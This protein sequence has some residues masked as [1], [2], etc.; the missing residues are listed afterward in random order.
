MIEK[1]TNISNISSIEQSRQHNIRGF[2]NL[3]FDNDP[4][5]EGQF[6]SVH[7]VVNIDGEIK[8]GYLV[9]IC[10]DIEPRQHA[11]ETI[12]LLHE[13]ITSKIG[14]SQNSIYDKLPS[15]MGLPFIICD[16]SLTTMD[17]DC[18]AMLMFD[19][20]YKGYVDYSDDS[21]G[22]SYLSSLKINEKIYLAYE[23]TKGLDFLHS[24]NFIHCDLDP[25]SIYIDKNSCSIALIDFDSGYI[26]DEQ[27]KPTTIGKISHYVGGLFRNTIS[28]IEKTSLLTSTDRLAEEE[29][30]LTNLIFELI[31]GVVPYFFLV[32]AD[33]STKRAY[34]KEHTWP[35]INT[36]SKLFNDKNKKAHQDIVDFLDLLTRSG[37]DDLVSS[38]KMIFNRGY[39]DYKRRLN[40]ND[41]KNLLWELNKDFENRPIITSFSSNKIQVHRRDEQIDFRWATSM[42]SQIYINDQL[43]T[44]KQEK[45]LDFLNSTLVKLKVVNDF[46][47]AE[48]TIEVEAVKVEPKIIQFNSSK[49]IRNNEDPIQLNWECMDT[50]K[51]TLSNHE[52]EISNVDSLYVEPTEKTKY[53]LTAEGYFGEL[54]TQSIEVDIIRPDITTFYS[55][56]NLEHGIDNVDLIWKTK[57]THSV[58]IYPKIGLLNDD[59][60]ICHIPIN[61]ETE[62]VLE[63]QGLFTKTTKTITAKPFPLPVVKEILAPAPVFDFTT[64]AYLSTID[65]KDSIEIP[66]IIREVNIPSVQFTQIKSIEVMDLKRPN[67]IDE[68]L[69][70]KPKKSVSLIDIFEKIKIIVDEKLSVIIDKNHEQSN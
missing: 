32:D 4:I 37:V 46:G 36:E 53:V 57:N 67:Y 58:S 11:L 1:I 25:H 48:K 49:D 40:A 33:D 19:L 31:V 13:R 55:E 35:Q 38:F 16:A 18:T 22:S 26:Y 8:Q 70:V 17:E 9:K 28:N 2:E 63:A 27:L 39:S 65:F 47:S 62:F 20:S 60:G 5:G 41:W 61:S 56:V 69:M 7:R 64:S 54:V 29:W 14:S 30:K 15:L 51:L 42:V 10:R 66:S 12:S 52:E 6:G 21:Y 23:I 3:T 34:L 24:I 50:Y 44:L 68:N 59:N 43:C 45:S